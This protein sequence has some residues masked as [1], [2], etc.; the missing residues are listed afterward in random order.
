MSTNSNN[1]EETTLTIGELS[2]LFK[3]HL[4]EHDLDEEDDDD[5]E[6]ITVNR[7]RPSQ[8]SQSVG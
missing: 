1:T 5:E 7:D 2:S 4:P 3:D 6:T 8:G